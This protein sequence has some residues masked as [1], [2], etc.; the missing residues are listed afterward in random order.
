MAS[1]NN[2]YNLSFDDSRKDYIKIKTVNDETV[3]MSADD[4]KA[5]MVDY[6]KTEIDF[7]VDG[8]TEQDKIK[9]K[10]RLDFKLKQIENDILRHIDDKINCITEKIISNCTTRIIEGEVDRRI[11]EKLK[12]K[13]DVRI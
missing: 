7:F 6:L 3:L 2:P 13:Y 12:I 9:F 1:L 10:D 8:I 4:L 5:I 11:N